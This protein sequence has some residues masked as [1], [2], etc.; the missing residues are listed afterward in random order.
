MNKIS[1]SGLKK[2]LSPKEMKNIIGGSDFDGFR[3]YC[4]YDSSSSQNNHTGCYLSA[5]FALALCQF[6]W[7]AGHD[8]ECHSC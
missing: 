1:Y 3:L 7:A 6:W 4:V 5:E 2:V 8:C